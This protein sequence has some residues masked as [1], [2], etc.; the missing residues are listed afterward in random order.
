M[1]YLK[2]NGKEREGIERLIIQWREG[3]TAEETGVRMREGIRKPGGWIIVEDNR[4][5]TLV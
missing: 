1:V 3:A 4:V 2:A 5:V